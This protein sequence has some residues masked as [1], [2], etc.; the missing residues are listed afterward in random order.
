MH[1][2]EWRQEGRGRGRTAPGTLRARD[3]ALGAGCSGDGPEQQLLT[4]SVGI[5]LRSH[6]VSARNARVG[7]CSAALFISIQPTVAQLP[8]IHRISRRARSEQLRVMAHIRLCA[9]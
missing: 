4:V 5:F 3:G 9:K 8:R 7:F 2:A 6:T 1:S